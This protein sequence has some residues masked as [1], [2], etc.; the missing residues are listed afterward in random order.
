MKLEG[1]GEIIASR[2]F[3]LLLKGK[4]PAEVVVLMGK[5]QKFPDHTDYYCPYEIKGFGPHRAVAVGGVDAFQ[6]MQLALSTIGV[7]LEVISK[8]SGGKLIWDADDQGDLGFPIRDW[9]NK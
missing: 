5:P 8:E 7:E 2:K 1:V 3:T 6:A 9:N 4:E